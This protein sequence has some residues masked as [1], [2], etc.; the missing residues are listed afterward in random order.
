MRHHLFVPRIA[1]H[2][3]LP[4]ALLLTCLL[5][6]SFLPLLVFGGADASLRTAVISVDGE[7]RRRIPLT[8]HE[9]RESFVV[10]TPTGTNEI[11]IDGASI[12]V[13]DAD[14]HD[15]ICIRTGAIREKGEA[16]AC[17]PHK[18]VIEIR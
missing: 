6:C 17:L 16:I 8:T 9:G 14:C 1:R 3:R 15:K 13:T 5:L 4:D 10:E 11:T 7:E 18:L 12:A 2:V